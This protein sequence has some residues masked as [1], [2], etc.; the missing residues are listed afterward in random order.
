MRVSPVDS[1][2]KSVPGREN[3]YNNWSRSVCAQEGL[4]CMDRVKGRVGECGVH[5]A[6]GVQSKGVGFFFLVDWEAIEGLGQRIT[7]YD[8][9]FKRIILLLC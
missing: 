8:L 1:W 2:K 4:E 9:S 5:G 7:S 6:T 3:S